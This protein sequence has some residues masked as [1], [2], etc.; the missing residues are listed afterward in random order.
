MVPS[1]AAK[2]IALVIGNSGY[3]RAGWALTNP[4][5][6]ARLI[7]QALEGVGFD[8][9][10][11]LDADEDEMEDAFARHGG[12]LA[13]AG[14]D[15]VGLFYYAGHGVQSRG[16]NYLV[17]V[18][19]DARSEQDVWAQAPR[20][21]LATDYIEAAGNSVNFVIL[22]ACRD[23]PLPSAGRTVAAGLAPAAPRPMLP[24]YQE[25][26]GSPR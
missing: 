2:R 26:P 3:E 7:A 18:D 10:L 14:A 17:P 5:N 15:A 6:D 1:A 20:L 23:N 21:G 11:V 13:A 4:V 9:E 8:V 19:A 16:F 24:Q 12:R 25:P 22:D